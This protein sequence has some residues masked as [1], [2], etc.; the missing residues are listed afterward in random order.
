MPSA[1][2]GSWYSPITSAFIVGGTVGLSHPRLDGPDVYWLEAR[3]AEAGRCVI[4]RRRGEGTVADVLPAPW[5]ALSKVHEMG[6]GAYTVAEG[7]VY[8]VHAA[9]QRIY[10]LQ[11]G[12]TPQPLTAAMG[13]VRYADLTVSP[14]RRWLYAVQE[15]HPGAGGEALN[16]L[17]RIAVDTGAVQVLHQGRDFYA[18]PRPHPQGDRLAWLCWDHPNMPWDGCELWLAEIGSHGL[19]SAGKIAGGAEEA[20]V[21][22]EW[23][24]D[25]ILYFMSDRSGWWN[26]YRQEPA[27]ARP[28]LVMAAE[29]A[30]PAWVFG[31]SS[32]AFLD[33]DRVLLAY[34]QQGLWRLGLLTLIGQAFTPLETPYSEVEF[35]AADGGR[36]VFV[37]AAPDRAP[38]VVEWGAGQ[39]RELRRSLQVE[40]DPGYLARPQPI[41]F[42]SLEGE[43]AHGFYYPPV[44][45]DYRA[46]PDERPPLRVLSHGGPTSAA[47]TALNLAIQYWTSR[48]FAVLDVNYGGSSGYGR[49]YRQRLDGRWGVVDVA[50]CVHGARWLVAQGLA[51]GE[52][53]II[54]GGSAGGYTTLAALAFTDTFRAGASYYGISDLE[55]LARDT[56]K[57]ESRYLERLVG[58]YPEAREVYRQRSPIHFAERLSCPVIFFQGLQDRIV[59]PNQAEGMVAALRARGI[60][61]AYLSFT[62][63]GHGFKRG[64]TIRRCLEG[65][66]YFYSRIFGFP[67]VEAVEPVA[68]EN[69]A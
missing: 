29:C 53:L 58:P 65:E 14:D 15:E 39:C 28:V 5:S 51:D 46:A 49:A 3:P 35:V 19:G 16:R 64:D 20:I 21:Q 44:N 63:E 43:T 32:Y 31:M 18:C 7:L 11:P 60:P 27:R 25:G 17:V 8:F 24:P 10:R 38:A 9:D 61:V 2:Y 42:A 68:I 66:L 6:G 12:D 67:L 41:S 23:S 4:V 50:D 47:S 54:R 69:L 36:A 34:C 48:G 33:A 22:P 62:E 55:L 45:R 56:H 37:G 52:R 30:R 13:D 57:F 40:L 1:P 26:L 59:P